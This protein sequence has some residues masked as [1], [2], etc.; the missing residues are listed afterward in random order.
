MP[1]DRR[2]E[3]PAVKSF[4]AG[5]ACAMVSDSLKAYTA[6]LAEA[7][8]RGRIF[9]DYLRNDRSATAYSLRGRTGTPVR[10]A[11]R[12]GVTDDLEPTSFGLASVPALVR[13]RSDP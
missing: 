11:A 12:L 13:T 1:I 9:I 4:A 10:H 7:A 6:V 5:L 2:H 3:W 8:R